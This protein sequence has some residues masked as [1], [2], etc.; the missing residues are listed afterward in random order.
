[1]P[2][3]VDRSRSAAG[4]EC[5][6]KRFYQYHAFGTGIVP[7]GSSIPLATGIY[8]HAGIAE[9]LKMAKETDKVPNRTSALDAANVAKLSYNYAVSEGFIEAREEECK[10]I[11]EEQ[12]A[13]I[14]ALV[15]GFWRTSLPSILDE[16]EVIL[17]EQEMELDFPFFDIKFMSR[18]DFVTRH[19]LTKAVAVRDLKTTSTFGDEWV[20]PWADSIQMM[21]Q[22]LAAEKLLGVP[23]EQ[24]YMDAIIKGQRR[25]DYNPDTGRYDL[26]EK[27]QNSHLIYAYRKEACPPMQPHDLWEPFYKYVGKDGK[28]HTLG[29]GW[30]KSPVW[31]H[32]SIE[33]WVLDALNEGDVAQSFKQVGPFQVNR[34][35]VEQWLRGLTAEE[36]LWKQ[37][38][39]DQAD[40]E[41]SSD[42]T[43]REFQ[44][45]LDMRF[46]RSYVCHPYG[47]QC[48]YYRLCFKQEGWE[49]PIDGGR[50][51]ER[52]PHHQAE[53]EDAA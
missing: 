18:P 43:S 17:V 9:L 50:Y 13:L 39:Q 16:N 48:P 1:M 30:E 36:V 40:L 45:A 26:G 41:K 49:T 32:S 22:A 3:Y 31:K 33:S 28:K 52:T 51:T 37:N 20:R 34:Y 29:K 21:G 5:R 38:V 2:W 25:H 12:S 42:W 23:V 7:V 11:A 46:P 10:A 8:V 24:Y 4:H 35:K 53:E 19:R 14:Q 15:L 47:A 6:A 44:D 27:K